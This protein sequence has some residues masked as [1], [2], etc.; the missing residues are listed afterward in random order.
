MTQE[1]YLEIQKARLVGLQEQRAAL[2][3]T[4]SRMES[5]RGYQ[6]RFTDTTKWWLAELDR[7]IAEMVSIIGIVR[8]RDLAA[9]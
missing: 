8:K 9:V 2:L 4:G 3:K 1:R 5:R 6:V 7:R